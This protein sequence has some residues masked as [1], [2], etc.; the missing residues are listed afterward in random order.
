MNRFIL[1]IGIAVTLGSIGGWIFARL[2]IPQVVGYVAIGVGA[3]LVGGAWF[4][5]VSPGAIQKS[6]NMKKVHQV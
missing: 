5:V 4:H 6:D 2:R 3:I 1:L